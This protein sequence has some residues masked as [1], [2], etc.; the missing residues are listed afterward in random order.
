MSK[1]NKDIGQKEIAWA[2]NAIISC[3]FVI[4]QK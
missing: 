4:S 3:S 2:G 1:A